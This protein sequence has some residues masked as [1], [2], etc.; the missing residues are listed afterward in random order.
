MHPINPF[1]KV[2]QTPVRSEPL[3]VV[4]DTSVSAAS[5]FHP[6]E[7]EFPVLRRVLFVF[8]KAVDST[9]WAINP[10]TNLPNGVALDFRRVCL[11]DCPGHAAR[12]LYQCISQ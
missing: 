1:R 8:I 7:D 4:R 10:S 9:R 12:M 11:P 2:R 6:G 5:S 3:V